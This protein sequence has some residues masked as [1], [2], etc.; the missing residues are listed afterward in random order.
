MPL[1]R[2]HQKSGARDIVLHGLARVVLHERH[3]LV[4][5]GVKDDLRT[6][7]DHHSVEPG[8]VGHIADNGVNEASCPRV[9]EICRNGEQTVFVALVEN[10]VGRKE[11][12]DLATKLRPDRSAG[13]SHHHSATLD[14]PPQRPVIEADRCAREQVLD[15]QVAD[16]GRGDSVLD[17]ASA[18]E[19]RDPDSEWPQRLHDFLNH[20]RIGARYGDQHFLRTVFAH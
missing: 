3:V 20:D 15:C 13:A 11:G 12:G 19:R 14:E 5:G 7:L 2:F 1:C 8:D 6:V 18:R 17:V 16:L 4:G 9:G 10:Q